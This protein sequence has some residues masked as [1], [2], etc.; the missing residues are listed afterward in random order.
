MKLLHTLFLILFIP[1]ICTAQVRLSSSEETAFR[2]LGL[3]GDA[4]KY[5]GFVRSYG[6]NKCNTL[7]R[8]TYTWSRFDGISLYEGSDLKFGIS[9]ASLAYSFNSALPSGEFDSAQWQGKGSNIRLEAGLFL[10]WKYL[11]LNLEGLFWYAENKDFDTVPVNGTQ[12]ENE[13][14]YYGGGT[15]DLYQCPN[16]PNVIGFNLGQSSVRYKRDIWTIGL[17]TENIWMGPCRI[18]PLHF[19]NQASGFPHLDIA[20]NG[21]QTLSLKGIEIGAVDTYLMLGVLHES[22]YFDDDSSNDYN[23]ILDM[24]F[25]YAFPFDKNLKIGFS[26]VRR[27]NMPDFTSKMWQIFDITDGGPTSTHDDKVDMQFSVMMSWKIESAGIEI[28]SEYGW[29]DNFNIIT[30]I[31]HSNAYSFGLEKSFSLKNGRYLGFLFELSDMSGTYFT[32]GE[33]S[34]PYWYKHYDVP[35]G[36]THVGQLLGNPIGP[37]SAAQH[38]G[39]N[40]ITKNS[41]WQW[42]IRRTLVDKDYLYELTENQGYSHS[43]PY[44]IGSLGTGCTR[45][46]R[47]FTWSVSA[48]YALH[49]N[50]G[51]Q[52][53]EYVHNLSFSIE[54]GF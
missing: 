35:Q 54:T 28:Y 22:D 8:S 39:V 36:H 34:Y 46:E 31:E 18:F 11:W 48:E 1:G 52:E 29:N 19:S 43:N 26:F 20:T 41:I 24:T 2:T 15:I 6:M 45:A 23:Q 7:N 47:H 25:G 13:Y 33:S 42:W 27:K 53:G 32:G 10:E 40:L 12:N 51:F 14:W 16:N 21:F 50:Y 9:T 30:R 3:L 44:V 37:G 5:D 17:G 49:M 4:D 38:F